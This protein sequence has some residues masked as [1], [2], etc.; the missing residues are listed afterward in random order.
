MACEFQSVLASSMCLEHGKKNG[1]DCHHASRPQIFSASTCSF[2]IGW[3]HTMKRQPRSLQARD[4][5]RLVEW[6]Q[7]TNLKISES[8]GSN[9]VSVPILPVQH[10]CIIYYFSPRLIK[11]LRCLGAF[12][13]MSLQRAHE[14][15]NNMGD[16]FLLKRRIWYRQHLLRSSLSSCR[17]A[18]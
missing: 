13:K 15:R 16:Q 7:M 10:C 6:I 11:Y 8:V 2:P 1:F 9:V 5:K 17:K 18:S 14:P 12:D 3:L 4:G